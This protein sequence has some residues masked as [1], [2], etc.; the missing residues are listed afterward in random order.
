MS[1]SVPTLVI[2]TAFLGTL[3]DRQFSHADHIRFLR[4]LRLLEEN[5]R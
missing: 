4:A 5:E 3:L 2:T 1:E